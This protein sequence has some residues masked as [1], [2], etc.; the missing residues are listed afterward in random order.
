[1]SE[2]VA[3]R[4]RLTT[5]AARQGH[6]RAQGGPG[7]STLTTRSAMIAAFGAFLPGGSYARGL[8]P[9]RLSRAFLV[10]E[11]DAIGSDDAA[12]QCRTKQDQ[13]GDSAKEESGDHEMPA[14]L[15]FLTTGRRFLTTG[16]RNP[17]RLFSDGS[18]PAVE[19]PARQTGP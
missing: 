15:S 9:V 12:R 8:T 5:Q 19:Q 11:C 3:G 4:S 16:R 6:R 1:M 14:S 18:P 13:A 2:I 7:Q 17:E 10:P